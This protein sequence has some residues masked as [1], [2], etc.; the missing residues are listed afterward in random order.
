VGDNVYLKALVDIPK[1]TEIL[2]NYG[3]GSAPLT[4]SHSITPHWDSIMQHLGSIVV[5]SGRDHTASENREMA[6]GQ[7]H[8]EAASNFNGKAF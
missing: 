2:I 8:T 5:E 4:A 1:N 3:P 6:L 7:H